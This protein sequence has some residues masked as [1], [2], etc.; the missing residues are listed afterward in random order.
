MFTSLKD[1][2]KNRNMEGLAAEMEKLGGGSFE[3]PETQLNFWK[4]TADKAGNGSAII[5]FLPACKGE[6]PDTVLSYTH[7][8]QGPTDKWLIENCP[9]TL[10]AG[11]ECPICANNNV[12]WEQGENSEGRKFVSGDPS[13]KPA[14]AGSKRKKAYISN[15]LVIKDATNKENEGKVFKFSYGQ[16]IHNKIKAAI[17]GDA[18]DAGIDPFNFWEGAN[19]KLKF[20]LSDGQR[21]YDTSV[22][23]KSTAIAKTD[24]AIEKIWTS[25]YS[26]EAIV[27]PSTFKTTEE[28]QKKLDYVMRS[29]KANTASAANKSEN[30]P[31]PKSEKAPTQKSKGGELADAEAD[32]EDFTSYLEGIAD[33]D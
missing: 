8:F 10:G 6:T 23:D 19:F 4:P 13:R 18:D 33:E 1:L 9:T 29:S 26:L 17:K 7:G 12:L 25:Q 32:S 15:I 20:G 11:T 31:E 5:R 16:K 30:A 14:R 27:A 3:K 22:F 28:L 24:D 2:K 21:S